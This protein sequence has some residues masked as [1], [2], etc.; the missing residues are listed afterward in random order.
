MQAVL[1]QSLPV[2][3]PFCASASPRPDNA[4]TRRLAISERNTYQFDPCL[5]HGLTTG[6]AYRHIWAG[7]RPV[8]RVLDALPER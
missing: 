8:E 2:G 7:A 6:S 1:P 4:R 5:V 3:R